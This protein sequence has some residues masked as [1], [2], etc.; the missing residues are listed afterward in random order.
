M[1]SQIIHTD[2]TVKTVKNLGWLLRNWQEVEH[3]HFDYKPAGMPACTLSHG[4]SAV[5]GM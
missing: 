4:Q 1:P 3:F 2:G 5:A